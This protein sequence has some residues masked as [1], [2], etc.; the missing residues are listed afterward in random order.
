MFT[1]VSVDFPIGEPRLPIQG[2]VVMP[3]FMWKFS[4]LLISVSLSTGFLKKAEQ[5]L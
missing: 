4:H 3:V 2:H 5:N 1:F